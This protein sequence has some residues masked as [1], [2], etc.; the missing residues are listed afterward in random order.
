MSF[1]YTNVD[2]VSSVP[3]VSNK[4]G[5]FSY[6]IEDR[7]KVLEW[8]SEVCSAM[9]ASRQTFFVSA[10]VLNLFL[11]R[12]ETHLPTTELQTAAAASISLASKIND[13]ISVGEVQLVNLT[14]GACDSLSTLTDMEIRILTV[15]D[16]NLQFTTC[17]DKLC[18]LPAPIN[19]QVRAWIGN[20]MAFD[21]IRRP[22]GT[23]IDMPLDFMLRNPLFI[24]QQF[25]RVASVRKEHGWNKK[26]K[27]YCHTHI[28]E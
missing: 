24:P 16:W 20:M 6:D 23:L 7:V 17:W 15:L 25:R 19:E 18:E 3:Q 8:I 10:N 9:Y 4:N 14:V 2:S 5:F 22:P 21:L 1:V 27:Y 28:F 11:L 26:T 12:C 13:V